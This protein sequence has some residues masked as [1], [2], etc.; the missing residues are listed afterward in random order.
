MINIKEL[1]RKRAA[2]PV[3]SQED[4]WVKEVLSS[5]CSEEW[6]IVPNG[7][8]YSR[9][10]KSELNA[11]TEKYM[12]SGIYNL[13][14]PFVD[15]GVRFELLHLTSKRVDSVDIG[16]FKARMFDRKP[17]KRDM[18]MFSLAE[19]YSAKYNSYVS[20]LE[21]WINEE[22]TP[23]HDRE[24]EYE[25]NTIPLSEYSYYH[26]S[27]EYYSRVAMDIRRL[28]RNE[29]T[30]P[31]GAVAEIVQPYHIQG[32]RG[33]VVAVKDLNYPFDVGD[34]GVRQT[35]NVLIEKNDILFPIAGSG[36]PYL[37]TEDITEPI[38]AS[39]LMAV[40]R[41]TGIQS[42]YLYLYLN[43]EVCQIIIES[44]SAG[45]AF[46]RITLA[47]LKNIPV[48]EPKEP[49]DVYEAQ[50]KA[51]TRVEKTYSESIARQKQRLAHYQKVLADNGYQ[52]NDKIEDILNLET[53]KK[54]KVFD[55]ENMR[56]FLT[57]DLKELNDCFRVKAYK[58]TLI[59]AGS[60][61]E[62]VLIDWL[63]DIDG[64]NYFKEEYCVTD[65]R[66]GKK[67]RAELIDYINEIKY[68]ERPHWMEEASKAHEIRKKRNLVHAKLCMNSDEVNED[69][70]RQV[71]EYLR[72][73]LK[74]RGLQ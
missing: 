42:E 54:I 53:A 49:A 28:L 30:V 66:T 11:L 59:L 9:R 3:S 71:I 13:G 56:S 5:N 38:Y 65:R 25:Y 68:I 6:L 1:L 39:P 57:A 58:A 32:A 69:V 16:I 46:K 52:Q 24:G 45:S 62:A 26:V 4:A 33:K 70:C 7:F 10:M 48:I 55:E 27:P 73:V 31:L 63:S 51:L 34:I 47:A 23:D 72:D 60:I 44:Q 37:V 35:S 61:L 18:G 36:K 64:V 12:I 50:V 74:T 67:K 8:F 29:K 41:C 20:E 19:D 2:Y 22:Y 14:S 15:T 17:L 40:I 43:S 21:K